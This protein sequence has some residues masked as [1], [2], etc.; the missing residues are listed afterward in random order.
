MIGL[1]C[2]VA[3]AE[4]LV[5]GA[6]A[7]ATRLGEQPVVIGLTVVAF[8]TSAPELAVSVGS[9]ISGNSDVAFGNVVGSNIVNIL[10]ILGASAV[11][12][13]LAVS[14]RIVR[15]DVPLLVGV[16]FV[17]LLMSLDN[18]IGRVDGAILFSGVIANTWWLI[19]ASRRETADISQEYAVVIDSFESAVADRPIHVQVALVVGGLVVLVIGSQLLVSSATDVAESLGVSDLVIGLTIVAIG[20]SLPEFATSIMAAIRGQR[21]IAVGN[22]IGSNLFNLMCV[23]GLTGIVSPDGVNVGDSSLRL[24]FPVMVAATIVL[25]P[26][27]WNGFQIR[28]WEGIV[29]AAFYVVY[30]AYLVLD[31]GDSVV[32]DV[33]A[34][35]AL[36]VTP[37]VL[38]TFAVAGYQGWRRHTSMVGSSEDSRS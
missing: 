31:E 36:I 27:M 37:L 9:A 6:A 25:V 16:S 23:L 35:A 19:R 32:A 5:K 12:G 21:D 8:G 20:T 14:Q 18:R 17:A 26:I 1:G 24:D 2:L 28:R 10:L 34:P 30:I 4:L 38:M 29:L 7:I 15:I 33:V 11:V 3:G 13:G 22:V